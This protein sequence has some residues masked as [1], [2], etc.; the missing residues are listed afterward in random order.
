MVEKLTT[1]DEATAAESHA[2]AAETATAL[3]ANAALHDDAINFEQVEEAEKS[4]RLARF[5]AARARAK[6]DRSKAAIR[7]AAAEALRAEIENYAQGDGEHFAG[8]LEAVGVAEAAFLDAALARQGQ[9]SAWTERAK[10]LGIPES[11]GRPVPP[12]ADGGLA[13]G[14]GSALLHAGRRVLNPFDGPSQL[15]NYRT[16]PSD[17]EAILNTVRAVDGVQ[18]ESSYEHFYRGPG[19]A[20]IGRNDPFSVEE[21]QRL[22]LKKLSKSEAWGE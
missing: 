11:D 15:E 9:L 2:A 8:L 6:A 12:A 4:G 10:D 14:R 19:G 21:V 20:V 16:R 1:E 17:R 3:L 13:L 7:V 18:A 22:E 5:K